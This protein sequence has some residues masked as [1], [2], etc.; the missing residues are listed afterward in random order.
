MLKYLLSEWYFLMVDLL[1]CKPVGLIG[2][3]KR[4]QAQNLL[5]LKSIIVYL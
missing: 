5:A 3:N 2:Q 1:E 4:I